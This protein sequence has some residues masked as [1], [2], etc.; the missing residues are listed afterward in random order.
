MLS[1]KK[2]RK[3]LGQKRVVPPLPKGKYPRVSVEEITEHVSEERDIASGWSAFIVYED[4]SGVRSERRITCKKIFGAGRPTYISAYCHERRSP[5]NFKIE[6]IIELFDFATG[7]MLDPSSHFERIRFE[8]ALPMKDRGLADLALV[9]IFMAKCDGH[10]HP[11]EEDSIKDSL[12]RYLLRS[13]GSNQELEAVVKRL[14]SIAPDAD[15]VVDAI[16]RLL[17]NKSSPSIARLIL[18]ASSEVMAA[19]GKYQSG[20]AVWSSQLHALLVEAGC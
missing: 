8:G 9:L 4:A 19:D 3:S 1:T 16:D 11:L 10:Y 17:T 5:R 7:E 20:E 18:D 14:P 12:S 6:R 15:D 2:L 13:G